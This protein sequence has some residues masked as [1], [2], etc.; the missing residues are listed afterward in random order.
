MLQ[1]FKVQALV[2]INKADLYPQ[3]SKDIARLC[4]AAWVEI[5]GEVPFDPTIVAAMVQGQPVTAYQPQSAAAQALCTIWEKL[6]ARIYRTRR[7]RSEQSPKT[8]A[9]DYSAVDD[10]D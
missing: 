6:A 5:I 7:W 8:S 1:H 2:V 10:G 4:R 9:G 3:G